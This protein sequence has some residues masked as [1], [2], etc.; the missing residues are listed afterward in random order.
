MNPIVASLAC[1]VGLAVLGY[2]MA[3][4]LGRRPWARDWVHAGERAITTAMLMV[5]GGG[6][7]LVAFG[8]VSWADDHVLA[9]IV[10]AVCLPLFAFFVLP[11]GLGLRAPLWLLPSWARDS[12][13]SRRTVVGGR[14]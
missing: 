2:A 9:G 3:L 14:R 7:G 10:L 1:A 13:R 4:R 8:V 11:A 5:P 6:A 12:V